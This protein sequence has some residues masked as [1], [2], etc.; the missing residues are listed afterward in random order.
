MSHTL[1]V[2]CRIQAQKLSQWITRNDLSR[3]WFASTSAS[4]AIDAEVRQANQ[5]HNGRI[6]VKTSEKA[7]V[8]FGVYALQSF[9][10]NDFLF[11]A[12]IAEDS[13]AAMSHSIQVD[14]SRHVKID[15]PG[16]FLNHSCEANVAAKSNSKADVAYD[17]VATKP[18]ASGEELFFDYDTTEYE[19]SSP[20]HCACGSSQCRRVIRGFKYSRND[21][22]DAYG[23]DNVASYL[24]NEQEH[25]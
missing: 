20:F 7:G 13:L 5:K 2:H 21:V 8:G 19:I 6:L 15:L 12:Y 11:Q 10:E 3:A 24:M 23:E 4:A 22:I 16:R 14:W 9:K 17:F 1:L 25:S 18:I